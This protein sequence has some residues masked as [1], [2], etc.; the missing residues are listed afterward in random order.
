[1][2]KRVIASLAVLVVA[3]TVA[4]TSGVSVAQAAD[5]CSQHVVQAPTLGG[6][7][8][9]GFQGKCNVN[10]WFSN[11]ELQYETGGKWFDMTI[12]GAPVPPLRFPPL[13]DG[14]FTANGV[15]AGGTTETG[16][17]QTP[18]C[19]FNLRDI[20]SFHR[21]SDGDTLADVTS[22]ETAKTC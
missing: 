1:M 18:Y 13:G 14:Y 9:L 12:N 5:S 7:I 6:G 20:G 3:A 21:N 16:I 11:D 19:S 17:D 8:T 2:F 15:F 10:W 22:P 4:L